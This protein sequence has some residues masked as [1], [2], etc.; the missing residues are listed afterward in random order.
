MNNEEKILNMLGQITQKLE[1]HDK[2]FEALEAGQAKLEAGQAKLEDRQIKLEDRQTT[3]E[4][5]VC[6]LQD[7][8]RHTQILIEN[9]DKKINL[10][11]EQHCSIVEKLDALAAETNKNND[12]RDRVETL[13]FITKEHAEKLRKLAKAE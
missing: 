8:V 7:S 1:E 4:N 12:L 13:E 10:I 5:V 6:Q 9:Q 3:L 11:A 2:R